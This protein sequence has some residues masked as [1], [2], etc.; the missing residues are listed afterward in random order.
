MTVTPSRRARA[1]LAGRHDR[2]HR[3]PLLRPARARRRLGRRPAGLGDHRH[4]LAGHGRQQRAAR[5]A[6][7]AR[8]AR[9]AA[10]DPAD[11]RHRRHRSR[12]NT[13][14]PGASGSAASTSATC[15]SPSP[16]STRSASSSLTDRPAILLGMDA[17]R[18]FDRVSVDFANRR[19]R[20]LLPEES[21]VAR[22]RMARRPSG[23]AGE[24]TETESD[25]DQFVLDLFF[26]CRYIAERLA[27]SRVPGSLTGEHEK[28]SSAVARGCGSWRACSSPS[29][30]WPERSPWPSSMGGRR[31]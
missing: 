2:R 14:S 26:F 5:A 27:H 24:L 30:R 12:P 21:K 16:T 6:G 19:V 20:V 1:A 28:K 29:R 3:P 13:A 23:P 10:P 9:R 17:L 7:A 18:L 8:P 4:R 25:P 11:Q 31:R 15:R 22:D